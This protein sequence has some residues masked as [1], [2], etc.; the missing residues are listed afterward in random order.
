MHCQRLYYVFVFQFSCHP[1]LG[2]VPSPY[3]YDL[4]VPFSN[5][6]KC[7]A[8]FTR[9]LVPLGCTFIVI[10]VSVIVSD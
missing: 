4:D 9:I 3:H 6:T 10:R 1:I 8:V 2:G 5:I 7:A